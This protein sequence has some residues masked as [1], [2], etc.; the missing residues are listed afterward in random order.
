MPAQQ[1]INELIER[2][3]S[4]LRDDSPECATL[5]LADC[6]AVIEY[7]NESLKE[8]R[9]LGLKFAQD[10]ETTDA[11]I[12]NLEEVNRNLTNLTFEY[13]I[14]IARLS[15]PTQPVAWLH[16]IV[17][18][19]G[20]V[21]DMRLSFSDHPISHEISRESLYTRPPTIDMLINELMELSLTWEDY[22]DVKE[23]CDTYRSKK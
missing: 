22:Q 1:E 2:I 15:A 10:R 14:E 16:H 20:F 7:V 12:D 18:P 11:K 8:S 17:D 19:D 23:V 3:D 4:Y 13:D 9:A 5:L 6:R 21:P